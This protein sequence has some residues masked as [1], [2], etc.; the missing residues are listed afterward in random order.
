MPGGGTFA[1]EL[2][3]RQFARGKALVVRNGL[4]SFRWSAIF[5]AGHL[6]ERASVL[7]ARPSGNDPQAPF[8]PAPL[9]EVIARIRA[10]RPEAV[11]APHVET[12]AGM[13]LPDAYLRALAEAAHEVGALMVLDCIA[14]GAAWVDMTG[15]WHRR[16]GLGTAK[17]LE[18]LALGRDRR[19]GAA[20]RGPARGRRPR[21]VSRWTSRNG[22]RS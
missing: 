5:D 10:E 11:F 3:A 12:S 6:N 18:R 8:A 22:A 21:T 14:S 9:D 2:V 17:G 19:A 1:M 15:S 7:M 16:A 20:G 13:I 4:F